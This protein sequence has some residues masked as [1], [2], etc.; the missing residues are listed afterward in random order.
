MT[1][2]KDLQFEIYSSK[3]EKE[4]KENEARATFEV[5]IAENILKLMKNMKP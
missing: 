3:S 1:Q 5:M 2:L 4:K